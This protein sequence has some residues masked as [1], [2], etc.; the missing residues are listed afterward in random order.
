MIY[1]VVHSRLIPS[2]IDKINKITWQFVPQCFQT[3]P[4]YLILKGE[5]FAKKIHEMAIFYQTTYYM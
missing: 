1:V 3:N 2:T 5:K 4:V